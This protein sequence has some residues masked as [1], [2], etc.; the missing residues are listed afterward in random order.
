MARRN[1]AFEWLFVAH[2]AWWLWAESLMVISMR[3]GMFALGRPGSEREARR[4]VSEKF[5]AAAMLPLA[6]AGSAAQPPKV[7]KKVVT[8]YRKRVSANRK[9]LSR[10]V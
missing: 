7:A 8:H 1:P 3:S 9:R 2:E 6:V 4:M 10:K 5:F